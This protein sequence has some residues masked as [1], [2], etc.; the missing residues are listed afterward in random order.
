MFESDLKTGFSTKVAE[1]IKAMNSKVIALWKKLTFVKYWQCQFCK[2][3]YSNVK[4]LL[5]KKFPKSNSKWAKCQILHYPVRIVFI[6][7]YLRYLRNI[8]V[9]VC[10]VWQV[11]FSLIQFLSQVVGFCHLIK[12]NI[13]VIPIL[14]RISSYN[15]I[16]PHKV[17]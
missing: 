14:P 16:N 5:I 15:Y 4:I 2:K 7:D 9:F 10:L 13:I 8:F 12:R 11:Q 17:L 3:K 6:V 1:N